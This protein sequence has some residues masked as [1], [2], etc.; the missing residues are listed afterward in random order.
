MILTG[1]SA[2]LDRLSTQPIT[3]EIKITPNS[4]ITV[5]FILISWR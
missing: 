2:F 4:P 1:F 3:V 5:V